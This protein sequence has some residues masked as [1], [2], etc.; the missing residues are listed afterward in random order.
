MFMWDRA[1]A[2]KAANSKPG[3]EQLNVHEYKEV[4]LGH[5]TVNNFRNLPPNKP[6]IGGNVHLL[7]TGAGWEGVLTMMDVDTKEYFQSDIVASLYPETEGR[8]GRKWNVM[9]HN[10]SR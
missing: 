1:L 9:P 10:F 7:D 8:G 3:K 4:Y 2:A 6:H 5:T